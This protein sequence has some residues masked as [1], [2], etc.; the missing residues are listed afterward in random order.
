M[1]RALILIVIAALAGACGKKQT[2]AAPKTPA[3]DSK[4]T[5]TGTA[6]PPAPETTPTQRSADPCEGGETMKKK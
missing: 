4:E 1:Q 6:P 5:G 3:T 2:T